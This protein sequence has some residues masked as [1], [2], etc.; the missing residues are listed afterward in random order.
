M[1][2]VNTIF[3]KRKKEPDIFKLVD[4]LASVLGVLP[5]TAIKVFLRRSL[6]NYIKRERKHFINS[7]P[8]CQGKC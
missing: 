3:L 4:E 7:N 8:F 1:K 5:T 2:N 6:P